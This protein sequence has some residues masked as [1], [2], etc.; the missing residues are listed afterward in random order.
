MFTLNIDPFTKQ[1]LNRVSYGE[2]TPGGQKCSRDLGYLVDAV[3]TDV[4]TGGNSYSIGFSNFYFD[5]NG[6]PITNG[7]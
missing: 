4:F 1:T 7:I 2:I 3:A 6:D 5:G